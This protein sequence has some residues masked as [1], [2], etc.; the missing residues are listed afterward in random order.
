MP[1]TEIVRIL[2]RAETAAGSLELLYDVT[3]TMQ[4]DEQTVGWP[5]FWVRELDVAG[6]LLRVQ[7]PFETED[8]AIAWGEEARGGA[9]D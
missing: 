9:W 8:E 7:G 3:G 5:R 6:R 1:I 4:P 2:A